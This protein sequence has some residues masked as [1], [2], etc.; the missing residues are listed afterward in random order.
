MQYKS[1]VRCG[2]SRKRQREIFSDNESLIHGVIYELSDV[3]FDISCVN[4][5]EIDTCIN[6]YLSK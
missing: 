5:I 2:S 4:E 3:Y 1:S 6:I